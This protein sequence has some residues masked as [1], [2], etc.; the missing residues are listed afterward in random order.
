MKPL[1]V[2]ND[3]RYLWAYIFGP[4]HVVGDLEEKEGINE[5]GK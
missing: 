2:S 1:A 4:R 3:V 5:I